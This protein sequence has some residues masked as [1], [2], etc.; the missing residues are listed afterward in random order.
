M[1]EQCRRHKASEAPHEQPPAPRLDLH[2]ARYDKH[3]KGKHQQNDYQHEHLKQLRRAPSPENPPKLALNKSQ[4]RL[5]A[6][7]QPALVESL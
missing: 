4:T 2:S 5:S 6:G 7:R 3:H 1:P